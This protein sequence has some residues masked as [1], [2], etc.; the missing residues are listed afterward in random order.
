MTPAPVPHPA[1]V[2]TATTMG[3]PTTLGPYTL[4]RDDVVQ[5][6]VAG[7]PDFSGVYLVGHDGNI[8]YGYV[9][10][11][12]ADG[13]TKEELVEVLTN[14]LKQYVRTPSVFVSIVGFNS[15]A[16]YIVGAVAQ[17][18][19]YAMRGDTVKIRDALIAAGL[20]ADNAALSRVHV[21]KADKTK[22]V[23]RL[24]NLKE[25]LYRGRLQDNVDLVNGDVIVV[26][27]TVW[28]R[29]TKFISGFV[30][31]TTSVASRTGTF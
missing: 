4:G 17:P 29:V 5:I 1:P 8:Q 23:K 25:V 31:P 9:G 22:P 16:V 20:L 14:Q 26:P 10:D 28:S 6:D 15:K 30:N 21:I 13:L 19:K 24:A 12:Q 2:P 27:W 3:G 7:Q 11:V 18:G